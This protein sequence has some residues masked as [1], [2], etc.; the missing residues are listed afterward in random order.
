M[1]KTTDERITELEQ[2]VAE[3]EKRLA[4]LSVKVNKPRPTEIKLQDLLTA[5]KNQTGI[6]ID[7]AAKE[8]P[9]NNES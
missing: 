8:R 5:I 7:P 2:T 4:A 1:S 9:E 6:G 3:L